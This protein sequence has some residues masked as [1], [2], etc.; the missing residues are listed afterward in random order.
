MAEHI[1]L[2]EK[3]EELAAK[4]L[5]EKGFEVLHRN[6]RYSHYEIDIVARKGKLLHFIE[7]KT[8]NHSRVGFPEDGVRKKK[9]RNLKRAADQYLHLNPGNKWIEFN[10]LAITFFK[11]REAEYFLFEDVYL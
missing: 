1:S 7:V 5:L 2:G 11:D 4:W 9:F 3:G 6:W 8:R 10:I